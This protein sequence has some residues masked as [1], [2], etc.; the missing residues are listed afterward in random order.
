MKSQFLELTLRGHGVVKL[1]VNLWDAPVVDERFR[2]DI[3]EAK[4]DF[5]TLDLVMPSIEPLR[6]A[7]PV[8]GAPMDYYSLCFSCQPDTALALPRYLVSIVALR[9]SEL[10]KPASTPWGYTAFARILEGAAFVRRIAET[11]QDGTLI[12]N[13]NEYQL[14]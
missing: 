2:K 5:A 11:K 13:V 9:S 10:M 6:K 14:A 4:F 12:A 8:G 7:Q 1:E 3:E